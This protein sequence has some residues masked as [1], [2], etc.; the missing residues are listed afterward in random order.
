MRK[1]SSFNKQAARSTYLRSSEVVCGG[2]GLRTCR[3][4]SSSVVRNSPLPANSWMSGR[5][6]RLCQG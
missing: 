3:P 4:M 1:G 5:E 6:G 2:V